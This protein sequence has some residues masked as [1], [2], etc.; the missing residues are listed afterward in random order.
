MLRARG[1]TAV[2][3]EKSDQIAARKRKGSAGGRPSALDARNRT[4]Y[5]LRLKCVGLPHR[6]AG[7]RCWSNRSYR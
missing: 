2:I 3:P 6:A 1:I 7:F 5:G 4:S